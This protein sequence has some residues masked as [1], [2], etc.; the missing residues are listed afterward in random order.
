MPGRPRRKAQRLAVGTAS[1][2]TLQVQNALTER[3]AKGG[4]DLPDAALLCD[5]KPDTVNNW[6]NKGIKTSREPY[7]SFARAIDKAK[8]KGRERTMT[9]YNG[10]VLTDP[11]TA[12]H[13]VERTNADG[14]GRTEASEQPTVS[15]PP[16]QQNV[17]VIVV[18][19]EDIIDFERRRLAE[20]R[21]LSDDDAAAAARNL[22]A[23]VTDPANS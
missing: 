4:L 10:H 14:M 23:L 3:L 9:A 21:G 20:E 2:L 15:L 6:Y 8:A 18:K 5:L 16:A 13:A 11:A 7:V 17:Q 19:P 12:R 1:L 22:D